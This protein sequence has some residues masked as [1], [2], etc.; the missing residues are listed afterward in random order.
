MTAADLD[1]LSADREQAAVGELLQLLDLVSGTL[2]DLLAIEI[3]PEE[4]SCLV[5]DGCWCKESNDDWSPYCQD[6]A[7]GEYFPTEHD[8]WLHRDWCCLMLFCAHASLPSPSK[9]LTISHKNQGINVYPFHWKI[10]LGFHQWWCLSSGGHLE[11]PNPFC[12]SWEK[13]IKSWAGTDCEDDMSLVHLHHG[14][15]LPL[16][17]LSCGLL[18][19]DD[20]KIPG[21]WMCNY[22]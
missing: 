19:P 4:K 1:L 12:C 16:L 11:Y 6:P 21:T 8:W 9:W 3:L 15:S 20:L 5:G 2:A 7:T 18:T 13:A 22:W 14:I 17:V 10:Y